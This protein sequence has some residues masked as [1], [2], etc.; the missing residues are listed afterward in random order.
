MKY[1]LL[2]SLLAYALS[3]AGFATR[4]WDCCKPDCSGPGQSGGYVARQCDA[5]INVI[6]DLYDESM[7]D[8]GPS[9]N[10]LDQI[11]NGI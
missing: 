2:I 7:C 5:N 3:K 9:T 1:L 4:F 11:S 10:C 6:T 8:G